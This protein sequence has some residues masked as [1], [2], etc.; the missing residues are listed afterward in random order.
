MSS[1]FSKKIRQVGHF[2]EKIGIF[3]ITSL[4]E[5]VFPD[6]ISHTIERCSLFMPWFATLNRQEFY[7]AVGVRTLP[8]RTAAHPHREQNPI[9]RTRSCARQNC[10]PTCANRAASCFFD[11]CFCLFLPFLLRF[12]SNVFC[13]VA[14]KPPCNKV[15]LTQKY[16][17][18]IPKATWLTIDRRFAFTERQF[19][20]A[21]RKICAKDIRNC[22]FKNLSSLKVFRKKVKNSLYSVWYVGKIRIWGQ[23]TTTTS[24]NAAMKRGR[25]DCALFFVHLCRQRA[26]SAVRRG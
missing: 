17:I 26:C 5:R 4:F 14:P 1:I 19:V 13:R 7:G 12:S 2:F 23:K 6:H 20:F 22:F 21:A 10:R 11:G 8:N 3:P 24:S 25:N 16:I 18:Y 15:F 9:G